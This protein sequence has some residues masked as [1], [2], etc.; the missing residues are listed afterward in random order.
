MTKAK[1]RDLVIRQAAIIHMLISLA[2]IDSVPA[3]L[4]IRFMERRRPGFTLIELLVTVSVI[5]ILASLLAASLAS[6]KNHAKVARCTANL[7]QLELGS[8]LY[9]MDNSDYFPANV[10]GGRGMSKLYPNWVGGVMSYES[11]GAPPA[12]FD[13]TNESILV[14]PEFGHI[15]PYTINPGTYK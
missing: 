7:K 4:I 10:Y 12:L 8:A 14:S 15:G 6:A 1:S 2:P 13:S 11:W 9:S 5:G 3:K